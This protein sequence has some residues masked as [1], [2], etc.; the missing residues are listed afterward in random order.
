MPYYLA[1]CTFWFNRHNSGAGELLCRLLEH[2]VVT[3]PH[4]LKDLIGG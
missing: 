3:A 2:A 4:P 1:E